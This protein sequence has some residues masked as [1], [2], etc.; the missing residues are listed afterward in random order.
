[1]PRAWCIT[2]R[3]HLKEIE[4]Q[5][6]NETK[7]EINIGQEAE[8]RRKKVRDEGKKKTSLKQSEGKKDELKDNKTGNVSI[9]KISDAFA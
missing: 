7:R 1:L 3:S 5:N 4:K 9:K 6:K 8:G 2:Y